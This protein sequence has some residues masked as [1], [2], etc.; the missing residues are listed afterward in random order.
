MSLAAALDQLTETPTRK[1][2]A[3][4]VG[5]ALAAIRDE[6][7]DDAHDKLVA[8]LANGKVEATRLAALLTENGYGIKAETVRRHRKRGAGSGCS[9]PV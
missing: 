1:G 2:P 9:C 4:T 7:G 3:C 6:H 5:A 8:L